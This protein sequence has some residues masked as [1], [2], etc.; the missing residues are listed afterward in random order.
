[1]NEAGNALEAVGWMSEKGFCAGFSTGEV[2]NMTGRRFR[3]AAA[4]EGA[5]LMKFRDG[6]PQVVTTLF[7][8]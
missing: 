5:S 4:S 6:S 1:M 3:P 8:C 7:N 2:R